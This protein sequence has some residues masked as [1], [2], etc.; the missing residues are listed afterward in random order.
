[1]RRAAA[2]VDVDAVRLGG[3]D[4]VLDAELLE[5]ERR[6]RRGGAVGAVDQHAQAG[7][8]DRRP[9]AA[10][11][12]APRSARRRPRARRDSPT[13]AP[14]G[15]APSASISASTRSSSASSSLKP[16]APKS[17]MPL[18]GNGLCEAEMTAP[19]A[20]ALLA[21][22]HRRCRA[23]AARRRAARRRRPR[24]CRRRARPRASGRSGA[25]RGRRAPPACAAPRSRANS[26][27][28]RGRAR[29]RARASSTSPLATP[30]TPSVP[31]SRQ[32]C[33]AAQRFEN[34]GRRR[35]PLRPAFLRSTSR[36][37]RVRKPCSLERGAQL[38]IGL[39]E[40]PG[41]A[42]A[43]RAGLAAD[44]AA[45]QARAHV[46]ALGLLGHDQGRGDDGAQVAA[47]EVLLERASVDSDR[48]A[49]RRQRHAGD[50]GLALAGAAIGRGLCHRS[51]SL[52][53]ARAAALGCWASCG[54]VGPAYTFSLRSCARPRR[55][56]GSMPRTAC[57]M[58]SSGRA[59]EHLGERA[60][61]EAAV[62][63]GVAV[64]DLLLQLLA[65]HADALG[66]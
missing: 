53:I 47:R 9:A 4:L 40:R 35:A 56:R 25:C 16:S 31:N 32:P 12:P 22:E 61:L 45:V 33:A 17:L 19:Q 21:H 63:P 6:D 1:M 44:A 36:A 64:V 2:V 49:A 24:R 7:T 18:S 51:Q 5:D 65:R 52:R 38:G 15:S 37:S 55:L 41:D 66:S 34:C 28:A 13:P 20:R 23:S 62:V 14:V 57:R 54:C 8:V 30:R 58:T 27:R 26:A 60:L 3:G 46:E 29:A 39:D 48:A 50:R 11:D 59:L 10:G 43:Q 42:V